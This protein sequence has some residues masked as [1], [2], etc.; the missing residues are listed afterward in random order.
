MVLDF[1]KV[2]VRPGKP[3]LFGRMGETRILGLPGN[4]LSCLVTARVFLVPLI[5]RLLGQTHARTQVL[6]ATLA[7]DLPPNGVRQHYLRATLAAGEGGTLLA[8]VLPSQ[9]SAFVAGL[10]EA[11]ALIVRAPNAPAAPAG[12]RV[13]FIPLDV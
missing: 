2:N 6:T 10:G 9:D 5:Q 7:Q 4:P 12:S 8:T 3:M 1:W 11:E 13:D